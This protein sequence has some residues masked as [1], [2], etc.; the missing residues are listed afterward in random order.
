MHFTN[1]LDQGDQLALLQT[2][3]ASIQHGLQHGSALPVDKQSLS[4]TL[5]QPRATFV[6]LNI[7]Q[8]LRGC[9]GSLQAQRAW[10]VDV[11]QNAFA[12]AFRDPRFPPLQAQE[13][14]R[15][16]LHISTLT[17]AR[18]MDVHSEAE[19][20]ASLRPGIDGLI[21]TAGGRRATFLPSV[22]EQLPNPRDFLNRLR[23]KAGVAADYWGKDVSVQNYQSE[24]FGASVAELT[25]ELR[26][27][28]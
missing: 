24:Y 27:Q 12:A 3:A 19:L 18:P 16:D 17:T 26:N 14:D 5:Q 1:Q 2:A 11:A 15:L 4:A 8:T 7:E 22:W 13:Y 10:L 20:L 25:L 28:G 9:M 21:F 23:Q 6:T